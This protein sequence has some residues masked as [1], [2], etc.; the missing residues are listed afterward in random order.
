MGIKPDILVCRTDLEVEDSIKEKL[1]LFCNVKK[2]D[3]VFNSTCNNLYEVPLMLERA[4][5]ANATCEHLNLINRP[6]N[7]QWENMI[8]NINNIRKKVKIAIV[9]KYVKLHD[10]YISIAESLK[11]G[12]Y[13]NNLEVEIEYIDADSVKEENVKDILKN[14]DGILVPGGFGTRGIEG[15]ITAIKYARENNIPFLGICLGMQMAVVEFA[16]NVLK[17]N[18]ANSEEFDEKTPNPVIHIMEEQKH[19]SSKGG[20]MRLGNYPCKI[21]EGSKV[22]EIYGKEEILERHR[23]RFE[24]NNKYKELMEKEGMVCSGISPDGNLVEI[25][26]YTKNNFF[27]ASQFHPEFISRPN[28]PAPLFKAFIKATGK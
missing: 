4:G 2:E 15:K 6:N 1:S 21:K 9:G 14:Q 27:I 11:H 10:A 24:F 26:E 17:L 23:H 19:I 3:V 20:T 22:R 16:R 25:I 13:A 12:G 18:D 7:K 8:E 28:N 5:L